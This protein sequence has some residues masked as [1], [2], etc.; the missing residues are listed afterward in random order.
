[1]ICAD[2]ATSSE[3]MVASASR[4]WVSATAGEELCEPGGGRFHDY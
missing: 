2:R 3:T 1:M 4:M